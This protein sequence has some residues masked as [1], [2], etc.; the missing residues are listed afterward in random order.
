MDTY[1]LAIGWWNFVGSIMMMFMLNQSIGNKIMVKWCLIFKE[2][3]A[4][5]YYGKLWLFWAAGLN[6]FFGLIN[7]MAVKWGYPEVKAFLIW[8]DIIAYLMFIGLSVWGL[9]AGRCAS[10]IYVAFFIFTV[11]ITWGL[12]VL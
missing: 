10:G 6:V 12:M 3:Y 1:L 11:W 4:V 2:K 7:I 5:G 8:T 9:I